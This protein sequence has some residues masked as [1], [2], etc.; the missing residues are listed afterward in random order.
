MIRAEILSASAGS[1]KTYR[2]A[3]KYVR[4]VIENPYAYRNV[5][6]VTFTN[7]AT[8]EMKSRIIGQLHCLA[9]CEKTP[10]LYDLCRDLGLDEQEVYSRARE[11][12]KLILHDYSR[13]TI[14]TIDTFFQRV[15]RA[16]VRELGLELDYSLELDAD[17]LISKSADTLI[18]NLESNRTLQQWLEDFCQEQLDNNRSWDV[19][20]EL[21]KIGREIFKEQNKN[22]LSGSLGKDELKA[23][24]DL[25]VSRSEAAKS[26]VKQLAKQAIEIMRNA[27]VDHSAFSNSVSK[28]FEKFAT[29]PVFEPN[30]TILKCT[31]STD[32]W[33][34]KGDRESSAEAIVSKLQMIMA[35]IVAIHNQSVRLWNTEA[36][37]K[38]NFRSFALL[39]DLYK[40]SSDICRDERTM[41]LSETKY[42]LSEFIADSDTPF[43]YEKIGSRFDRFMIDEFQDTSL[44]EW[45]NF[46]PL[47]RNSIAQSDKPSVLLVGDTKQAIYR[48]RGG[49][50]NILNHLAAEELGKEYT[51]TD[52]LK[53]NYRSLPLIVEFNNLLISKAVKCDN[54]QINMLLEAAV[55][56]RRIS[57]AIA[58]SLKDSLLDTYSD[59]V[60]EPHIEAEH[61]GYV[62]ITIFKDDEQ[63][64][65]VERIKEILDKGFKP[66]DIMILV[67]DKNKGI[68][69]AQML[70]EFKHAN[71]D[72]R[73]RFD[74]MTQEAL[75]I[76]AS[77]AAKF[78]TAAL[79][80]AI[81]PDNHIQRA[82]FRRFGGKDID[83][84]LTED[85]LAFFRS[86][87]T[88][89]PEEAF[90]RIVIR[91]GLDKQPQHTAYLQALHERIVR[92][93][94]GRV[95]D[96]AMWLE[97]WNESESKKS[98]SVEQGETTIEI[99][100]IHKAKGLEK[101]VVI[102][103]YCDWKLDPKSLAGSYLWVQP[104]GDEQLSKLG[105]FPVPISH[106]IANSLFAE[107]F[108][109]ELADSHIDNIN[110][111]Y[112]ALTRPV[113]SLH[114]FIAEPSKKKEK[115]DNVGRL[116][117][118]CLES[119]NHE[120]DNRDEN[121]NPIYKYLNFQTSGYKFEAD[122]DGF[123]H[124]RFGEFAPPCRVKENEKLTEHITIDNY[125]THKADIQLALPSSR[126]FDDDP[127]AELSPRNFGI[128]MHRVFAEAQSS[129]DIENA[130]AKMVA[131]AM[132]SEQE[133]ETLREMIEQALQNPVVSS[134]FS[135]DGKNREIRNEN[136]IIL[137]QSSSTRRP[138]RV[139]IEGDKATVIDYKFGHEKRTSYT[140]QINEYKS[141]LTK[142]G[143]K[144]VAGYI[145]YVTAGEVERV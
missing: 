117:I 135:K 86:I 38:S 122:G 115:I 88:L 100:T 83:V 99:T 142:M 97:R 34:R 77:P 89:S 18:K 59:L 143:Y 110:L 31:E 53:R 52:S 124:L 23:I 91:F 60:Q 105:E 35:E 14:L 131:D 16:F 40:A 90:E 19:R 138:D 44:K 65:V 119:P 118:E 27:G 25:F 73:Y 49:D 74:V 41:L 68:E 46:L 81:N 64:P 102:I 78:V 50:R 76:G 113:E 130:I 55:K 75:I 111:L 43:I 71:E 39:T 116:I 94:S 106:S 98:L 103:P 21:L 17:A 37:I 26:Q 144:D 72:P 112:V 93:C 24:V 62:D 109:L 87:R 7:K 145:W 22:A 57:A 15:L 134:W 123:R 129:E 36:A 127:A 85:E 42:L 95:A 4:N 140:R 125:L 84:P 2:L 132:I 107:G 11:V 8:E 13:F 82:I 79:A 114:I 80:L 121:G 141:L 5:I 30:A 56:E 58:D 63:P 69:I 137:P 66:K 70:L 126:Y 29:E 92:F 108:Y 48:W 1:G 3:Y 67:R 104:Q 101:K 6:A 133:A 9:E 61:N 51:L 120:E 10:Y 136:D 20:K 96:I 45:Y 47:L 54:T 33:F 139:I 12:Q 28:Y 128:L 32:K